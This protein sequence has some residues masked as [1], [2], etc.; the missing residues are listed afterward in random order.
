M[1]NEEEFTTIHGLRF[2]IKEGDKDSKTVKAFVHDLEHH[3]DH[4]KLHSLLHEARNAPD[5]KQHFTDQGV[6]AI[7]HSDGHYTLQKTE[8]Y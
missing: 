8:H 2:K 1:E 3:S 4:D 7:H 5:G 6:T